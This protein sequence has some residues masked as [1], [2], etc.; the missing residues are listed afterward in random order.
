MY[1]TKKMATWNLF[2]PNTDIEVED[3]SLEDSYQRCLEWMEIHSKSFYF[4]S[5]FLPLQQRKS[6]AALYAFCRMTDDIVD[7]AP[8]S[9]TEEDINLLLDNLRIT[10]VKLEQGYVSS[11]PIL[12]AF[13]DTLFRHK[14]PVKYVHDLIEGVRMDLNKKEYKTDE[15][16]DLYMYRV[17]STVGLMM[18]HIFLENPAPSTLARAADLGKAMQLTNILRDIKEDYNKGRIY[19]PEETRKLHE[20]SVSDF[21]GHTVKEN[22]KELIRIE[23]ERAKTFY[24]S[25]DIGIEALPPAGAYTVKVA[26][27][28]YEDILNEIKRMDY[29]VLSQRAVVSKLRK[30]IIATK[31]RLKF[32]KKL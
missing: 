31:I 29:Q 23:S 12:Y 30:I 14:I 25:A 10:V 32:F 6:V 28:V 17:A 4:A 13:G 1:S 9:T 26:S 3:P 21:T 7:E 22:L 20:V 2:P 27:S 19:L 11:D 15:E 5:R 16:L 18:T 8:G 24:R